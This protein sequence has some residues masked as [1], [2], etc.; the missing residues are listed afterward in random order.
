MTDD[1]T[2][3]LEPHRRELQVHL[4]RMTG[5]FEDAEDL[6][7]ETLLRAWRRRETYEGRASLRAW[8]YRIAT[9]ACLDAL[10]K[11]PRRITSGA[12]A[13]IPWLQPFPDALLDELAADEHGPDA[14]VVAKETIELA[15]LVAIQHLPPRQRA[16]LLARDVLTFSA[17]ETAELLDLS[18]AA[19]NSALQRAHATMR[20]RLPERR[21]EWTAGEPSAREGELLARY[22]DA[23]DRAD[24]DA[25]AALLGEEMRFTMPPNTLATDGRH[26]F[27][28]MCRDAFVGPEAIG[29]FRLVAT[30]ANRQPAAAEYVRAPGE[31]VYKALGID[32]LTIEDERIVAVTTFEAH[33][34]GAFGLPAE[35]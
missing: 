28:K 4:Y 13:E 30:R 26:D 24:A 32:V 7:Q 17:P 19:V 12:G 16:V 33:L 23:H 34:F 14:A 20:E 3:Q 5:S 22:V 10:A 31:D 21:S 18:V 1:F 6:V 27:V 29:H 8:L 15:F 9:N 25:L 11:R 35:L 2:A